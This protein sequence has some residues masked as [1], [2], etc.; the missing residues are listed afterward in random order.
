M[1]KK[2]ADIAVSEKAVPTATKELLGMKLNVKKVATI[3]RKDGQI[4]SIIQ[5]KS[6]DVDFSTLSEATKAELM[7]K[8]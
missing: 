4:E 3:T 1:I 6:I 5:E 7:E 8:F 2:I